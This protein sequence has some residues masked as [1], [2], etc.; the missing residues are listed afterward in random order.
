M[1]N[2][3]DEVDIKVLEIDKMGRVNLSKLAADIELG[4]VDPSEVESRGGGGDRGRDRGGDRDR[5][6]GGDRDRGRGGDR[7]G[8][9]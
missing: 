7:G 8:R 5:G 9:R 4:R 2:V 3:G 1:V 6:R